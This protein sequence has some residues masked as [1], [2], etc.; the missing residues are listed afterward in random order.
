L[1]LKKVLEVQPGEP[2]K[3]EGVIL[4]ADFTLG[5]RLKHAFDA[6]FD[7]VFAQ[8]GWAAHYE[9]ILWSFPAL[10]IRAISARAAAQAARSTVLGVAG[11]GDQP[12]SP[13]VEVLVQQW[14]AHKNGVA[15]ALVLAGFGDDER[16]LEASLPGAFLRT[17]AQEAGLPL[18]LHSL[19]PAPS[20]AARF[21][22]DGTGAGVAPL[23]HA[24]FL[25]H[26]HP[27]FSPAANHTRG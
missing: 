6:W 18:H 12:L 20:R 3:V 16:C 7:E 15:R 5:L 2:P 9:L 17:A 19:G 1:Y 14:V 24:N 27:M 21:A 22:D 11:L 4:Y 10:R 13:E 8:I 26:S 23:L 25:R